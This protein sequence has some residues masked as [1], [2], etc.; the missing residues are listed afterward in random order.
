MYDTTFFVF[1]FA[2]C[3]LYWTTI[4]ADIDRAMISCV[5]HHDAGCQ[6]GKRH[7]HGSLYYHGRVFVGGWS[8]Q[9]PGRRAGAGKPSHHPTNLATSKWFLCWGNMWRLEFRVKACLVFDCVGDTRD[10]VLCRKGI[11]QRLFLEQ[12]W[13]SGMPV[14]QDTLVRHCFAWFSECFPIWTCLSKGNG[15]DLICTSQESLW[16]TRRQGRVNGVWNNRASTDLV[17]KGII[18]IDQHLEWHSGT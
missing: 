13:L 12:A 7:G 15:F 18:E 8:A 5:K 14:I 17:L 10:F 11:L 3:I 1:H 16:T 4:C 6:D 9:G 2:L